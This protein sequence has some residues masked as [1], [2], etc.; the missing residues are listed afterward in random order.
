MPDTFNIFFNIFCPLHIQKWNIRCYCSNWQVGK[1]RS[2]AEEL[3]WHWL[4]SQTTGVWFSASLFTMWLWMSL[5]C[6]SVVSSTNGVIMVPDFNK[7]VS[8]CKTL[9]NVPGI[10]WALNEWEPT[11]LFAQIT[12]WGSL[13]PVM[14]SF[15]RNTVSGYENCCLNILILI[16]LNNIS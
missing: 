11:L 10:Q 9:G 5:L 3:L 7:W 8:V 4:W 6:A 1:P 15:Q 16:R 14:L 2:S 12:Q 13:T